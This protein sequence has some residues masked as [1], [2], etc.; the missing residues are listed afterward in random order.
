MG[1]SG[2]RPVRILLADHHRIVRAG[3]QEILKEARSAQGFATTG[4][5]TMEE[6]LELL[7]T[8][9][10]DVAFIV[11]DLPPHGGIKATDLILR[12][13]PG[14]KILGLM[15]TPEKGPVDKM[16]AAGAAG[17][18][19]TNI[20]PDTLIEAIRTVLNGRPY[21]SNDIALEL[22]RTHIDQEQ[23]SVP[24]ITPKEQEI[25]GK[26]LCGQRNH[27]IA[28][29]MG[30][31]RRTVAKHRQNINAKLGARNAVELA[32]RAIRFGLAG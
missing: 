11:Y 4:A 26:I 15:T 7:R 21:F 2:K 1:N 5:E 29:S 25:L 22:N 8:Q 3:F 9:K 28:D 27:E 14:L 12:R 32:L 10:F 24:R 6:A 20:Q 18:I 16:M 31:S 19:L 30:I 17:C 23:S 13:N